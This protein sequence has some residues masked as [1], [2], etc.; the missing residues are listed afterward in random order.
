MLSKRSIDNATHTPVDAIKAAR[1]LWVRALVLWCGLSVVGAAL[2][3]GGGGLQS[4]EWID[5]R[6]RSLTAQLDCTVCREA[7]AKGPWGGSAISIETEVR[8]HVMQGLTDIEIV[9]RLL[10]KYGDF[11][12]YQPAMERDAVMLGLGVGAVVLFASLAL[13]SGVRRADR[14]RRPLASPERAAVPG[15]AS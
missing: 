1:V 3:I 7:A 15:D 2:A 4:A 11:V 14:M 8:A 12:R 13:V 5:T 10:A 6:V 9:S